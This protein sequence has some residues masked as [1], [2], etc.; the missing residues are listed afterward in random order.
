MVVEVSH[1]NGGLSGSWILWRQRDEE[2]WVSSS[3][4]P[5]AARGRVG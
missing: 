4:L 3:A 5:V 2:F 1:S